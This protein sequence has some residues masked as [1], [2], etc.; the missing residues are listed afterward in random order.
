VQVLLE[1]RAAQQAGAAGAALVVA[2]QPE[3]AV[4]L[5][6]EVDD[7]E[8]LAQPGAAGAAGEVHQRRTGEVAGAADAEVDRAGVDPRAV[9]WDREARA[10]R[11][12]EVDAGPEVQRGAG[13]ARESEQRGE[14]GHPGRG[15][16]HGGSG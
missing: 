14:N 7:A 12:P 11:L 3:A 1:L 16:E 6:N 2:D 9:Q 13:G 5:G 15:G 10:A 4:E 8:H